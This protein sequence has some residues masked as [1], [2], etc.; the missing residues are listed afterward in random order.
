MRPARLM[1]AAGALDMKKMSPVAAT[2][3]ASATGRLKS[4]G[5]LVKLGGPWGGPARR[6]AL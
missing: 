1:R 2:R 5:R 3:V 6:P 4:H